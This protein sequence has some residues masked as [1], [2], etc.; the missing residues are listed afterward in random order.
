VR[1]LLSLTRDNL[2]QP[3]CLICIQNLRFCARRDLATTIPPYAAIYKIK[4]KSAD[5]ENEP[6][7]RDRMPAA[8]KNILCIDDETDILEIAKFA[9]ENNGRFKFDMCHGGKEALRRAPYLA[10][11]LILL[12]VMMPG[13]DGMAV[14]RE[15]RRMP[16]FANVPVAFMT[17]RVQPAEVLRYLEMGVEGVIPKPFDPL[18]LPDAVE[19]LWATREERKRDPARAAG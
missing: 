10:P 15:L 19:S 9:L 17:A 12:D 14:Y 5:D 8:P 4:T 1:V 16:K 2:R 18:A 6:S 13:M 3:I 7:E 11:D